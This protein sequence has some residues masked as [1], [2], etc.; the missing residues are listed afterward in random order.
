[1]KNKPLDRSSR[2]L[3]YVYKLHAQLRWPVWRC[4]SVCGVVEVRAS[5]GWHNPEEEAEV[6]GSRW[7][8][9]NSFFFEI[10]LLWL[11]MWRWR[12]WR[13]SVKEAEEAEEWCEGSKGCECE[14]FFLRSF[15]FFRWWA[16]RGKHLL[17]GVKPVFYATAWQNVFSIWM[18]S[19]RMKNVTNK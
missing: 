17:A 8:D 9:K 1:M 7:H 19:L 18:T 2:Q 14:L 10:F 3:Q 13:F 11:S 16:W 4:D 12:W 6:W 5:K 15:C